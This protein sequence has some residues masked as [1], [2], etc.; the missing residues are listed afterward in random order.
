MT[1]EWPSRPPRG[2]RLPSSTV[3]GMRLIDLVKDD[4]AARLYENAA[5]TE[6]VHWLFAQRSFE[7]VLDAWLGTH[8]D[9]ASRV[10]AAVAVERAVRDVVADAM[11][12]QLL[13]LDIDER[14]RR[15]RNRT[16]STELAREAAER[17]Q[18]KGFDRAAAF[19]KP[20]EKWAVRDDGEM[21]LPID[22]DLLGWLWWQERHE[23][24]Y[25]LRRRKRESGGV[26]DPAGGDAGE[27]QRGR[28]ATIDAPADAT[29]DTDPQEGAEARV[30]AAGW[31]SFLDAVRHL[32]LNPGEDEA[33]LHSADLRA[34]AHRREL[35]TTLAVAAAQAEVLAGVLASGDRVRE[36][37][38]WWS[39][40]DQ[41]F[42][43]AC[44]AAVPAKAESEGWRS[45]L[46]A[47]VGH[48]LG[49]AMAIR[50]SADAQRE[51]AA[52]V[53]AWTAAHLKNFVQ[54]GPADDKPLAR[55]EARIGWWQWVLSALA[56][57][58]AAVSPR[59]TEL[60]G[61][62]LADTGS[63]LRSVGVPKAAARWVAL[64]EAALETVRRRQEDQVTR[65]IDELDRW[66]QHLADALVPPPLAT[67]E[68]AEQGLP[69]ARR[70]AHQT[71]EAV[72]LAFV[73]VSTV[74]AP[75]WPPAE[76]VIP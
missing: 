57:S 26:I 38:R 11:V 13:A 53:E 59:I 76:Q 56:Q 33:R 43:A 49:T 44:R 62:V 29:V 16:P 41:Q 39:D 6:A 1:S 10:G 63:W 40:L 64:E 14:A 58:H 20:T 48:A 55:V 74:L 68:L 42:V 65:A 67:L 66:Q 32:L 31:R 22:S 9:W 28:T 35:A 51:M 52:A 25:L 18:E 70:A 4:N 50:A 61:E 3:A 19:R 73:E 5:R 2:S 60:A 34:G 21:P 12:D 46:R 17:A 71:S 8:E 36:P 69:L 75:E 37:S 24:S 27:T 23:V 15:H 30:D 7:E 72:L 45:R 47:N 54:R